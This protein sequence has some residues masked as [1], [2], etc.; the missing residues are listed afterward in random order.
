MGTL[1]LHKVGFPLIPQ[2][3]YRSKGNDIAPKA[4]VFCAANHLDLLFK[5]HSQVFPWFSGLVA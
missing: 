3:F 5:D 4:Q 1:N 2:V